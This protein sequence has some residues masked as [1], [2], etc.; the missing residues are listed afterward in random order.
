MKNYI[1]TGL[2]LVLAPWYAHAEDYRLQQTDVISLSVYQ[3]A[4]M[5]TEA[6]IG[7]SGNVSLPLIGT[8]EIK[9]LTL[10][11]AEQKVKELYEKDYLVDP[12]VRMTIVS[13]AKKWLTVAGAVENPGNIAYPEEG[14]INLA[15]AVAM[16]G[17]VMEMGNSRNITVA[18]KA[19]GASKHSLANSGKILLLPGD[20]VVVPRLPRTDLKLTVR[21]ST[22]SGEVKN[23]GDISLPSNGKIDILTAIAKAGGFSKVANQK[24]CI[25]HRKMKTGYKAIDVS[26]RNIRSGKDP[27]VFI[28]QGDIIIIK[29]SRF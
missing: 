22:V 24:E 20:T 5:Q 9:G 14:T 12:K 26:I 21:T 29:E 13:Y 6:M 4:D 10:R 15:S 19:G 7:K 28:Y 18:R 27:M 11:E 8:V 25:L 2:L 23:P 17:G 3:E 1:L 16:A